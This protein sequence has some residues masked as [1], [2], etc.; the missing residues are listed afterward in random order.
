L[1][2]PLPNTPLWKLT[3]LSLSNPLA[4]FKGP[5]S[6]GS[7]GQGRGRWGVGEKSVRR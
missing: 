6:M 3:A 2:G 5:T 7:A 4:G 1:A